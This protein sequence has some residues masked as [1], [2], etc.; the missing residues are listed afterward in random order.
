MISKITDTSMFPW[1]CSTSAKLLDDNENY[2][3]ENEK[4]LSDDV[5]LDAYNLAG[6]KC[7]F[8]RV[9]EDLKRDQ[10][11][12]E[13]QLK[14]IERSWYFIGY[15]SQLPPNVRTY[16][17]QGIYG[18]DT[19]TMYCSI[20]AFK[21]YSTYGNI[22]KNTPEVYEQVQPRID[23]IIYLPQNE[24]FYRIHDVKYY[25]EAFGLAKHTYTLTLKVYKDNK[26]TISANS[27]TLSNPNDPVYK[28]APNSLSSQYNI[29]DSLKINDDIKNHENVNTFD[30]S[31]K[32]KDEKTDNPAYYDPFGGW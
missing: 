30:Y 26:W 18:E 6:L 9:Y 11:F 19:I 32:S 13:D 16:Q 31:Y 2:I 17:L 12:G 7:I 25:T 15:V 4:D 1:L 24:V 10:L 28:I 8:Y 29:N 3:C 20:N 23:D 22:D 27:P 21:Y 5:T 14:M